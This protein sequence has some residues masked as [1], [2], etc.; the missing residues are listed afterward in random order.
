[1]WMQSPPHRAV[2][3]SPAGRRIGVGKRRGRLGSARRAVFTADLAS[4]H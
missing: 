1:M 3:L 4:R 2:L